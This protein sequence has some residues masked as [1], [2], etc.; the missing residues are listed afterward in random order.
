VSQTCKIVVLEI[1]DEAGF[2]LRVGPDERHESSRALKANGASA[3]SEFSKSKPATH[4][5]MEV[6]VAENDFESLL[7]Q[8]ADV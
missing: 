4:L 2:V 8:I 6:S 3:K 1:E 5:L 7:T